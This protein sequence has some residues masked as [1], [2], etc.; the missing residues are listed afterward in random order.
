MR[1]YHYQ[2]DDDLCSLFIEENLLAIAK[3]MTPLARSVYNIHLDAIESNWDSSINKYWR[4]RSGVNQGAIKEDYMPNK[5]FYSLMINFLNLNGTPRLREHTGR[6][7]GIDHIL[8]YWL[9]F[10]PFHRNGGVLRSTLFHHGFRNDLALKVGK[11]S[12]S[13][14]R[15]F[16][17]YDDK[18]WEIFYGRRSELR[19]ATIDTIQA[20]KRVVASKFN[21]E[22]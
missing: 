10:T 11:T 18:D 12:D 1:A 21:L 22:Y 8:Q 5:P 20:M 7:A 15:K 4:K 3:E 13:K 6:L 14:I 2:H 17:T 9:R 19:R 16:H